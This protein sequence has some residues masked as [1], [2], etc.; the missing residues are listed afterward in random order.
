MSVVWAEFKITISCKVDNKLPD[1]PNLLEPQTTV[2]NK[3]D[4]SIKMRKT[5]LNTSL[6]LYS[7]I[8]NAL[9]LLS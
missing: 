9:R 8:Y 2:N 6:E 5:Q 1:I 7:R 4:V 3:M